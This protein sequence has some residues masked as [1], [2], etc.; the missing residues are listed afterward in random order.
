MFFDASFIKAPDSWHLGKH[1]VCL[2]DGHVK[3]AEMAALQSTS[4]YRW[5]V[6]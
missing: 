4:L 5:A 3:T 6:Q 1:N 2:A